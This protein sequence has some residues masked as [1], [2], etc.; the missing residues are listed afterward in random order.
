MILASDDDV[1]SPEYLE[2]MNELVDKYPSVNVFRPRVKRIDENGNSKG[3]QEAKL[4]G[5]YLVN[6]ETD[7]VIDEHKTTW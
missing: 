1:Y 3:Q 7:E 2:R 5:F 4:K 6:L